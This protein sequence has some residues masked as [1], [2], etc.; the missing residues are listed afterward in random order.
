MRGI[1]N[2]LIA[3]LG[4]IFIGVSLKSL[5]IDN[6]DEYVKMIGATLF[7]LFLIYPIFKK[8]LTTDVEKFIDNQNIEVV[9]WWKRLI[10]FLIDYTI[11][12]L[13]NSV[14]AMLILPIITNLL[15]IN[16][17]DDIGFV[18]WVLFLLIFIFYYVIQEYFFKTTVGKLLFKLK[19]VSA[20]TNIFLGS[21][22]ST[23]PTLF[24]VFVRT[25]VR[26]LFFIDIFF[27]L[28]KRPIG[29]H[30]IISKTFVTKK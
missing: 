11:I 12:I 15:N 6:S 18:F 5:I 22:K 20:K 7:G 9:I 19:I 8:D 1:K 27:F 16:N 14:I 28:F 26:L 23:N 21:E 29:L 13:L 30:D 17:S 25:I 3:F 2:L 24:Q 4:M 10:G